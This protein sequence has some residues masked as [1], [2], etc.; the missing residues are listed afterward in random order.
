MCS[1]MQSPRAKNAFSR[2]CAARTWPAPEV[3][4]SNR[5]RGLTFIGRELADLRMASRG[6]ALACGEPLQDAAPDFLQFA[7]ARQV[8]LEIMVQQ[9]RTVG[10]QLGSQNHV[11]QFDRVREQGVFLQLF[12]GKARI[13]VIHGFPQWRTKRNVQIYCTRGRELHSRIAERNDRIAL[14]VQAAVAAA[15]RNS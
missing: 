5:T 8:I 3:A 14:R 9:L 4:E 10:I 12:Q 11:A 6:L 7:K 13:V 15:G 1:T 2:A